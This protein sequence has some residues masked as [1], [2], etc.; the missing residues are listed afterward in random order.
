MSIP[1]SSINHPQAGPRAA[2]TND[3]RLRDRCGTA[4]DAQIGHPAPA[5]RFAQGLK[6]RILTSGRSPPALSP[7]SLAHFGGPSDS[8]TGVNLAPPASGSVPLAT[9]RK[10]SYSAQITCPARRRLSGA[11]LPGFTRGRGPGI[12]FFGTAA[13]LS[14][15]HRTFGHLVESSILKLKTQ[16]GPRPQSVP[17]KHTKCS[18]RHVANVQGSLSARPRS[19][20]VC[21]TAFQ[22]WPK[23]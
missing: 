1:R 7:P 19:L 14:C 9:G 11:G 22:S 20:I 18:Q 12:L 16:S 4:G 23:S 15:G 21:P 10:P 5:G 17:A 3:F 6:T 13:S 2:M 8:A